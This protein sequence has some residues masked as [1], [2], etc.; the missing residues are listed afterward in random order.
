MTGSSGPDVYLSL[1]TLM[2][3][4]GQD[5]VSA[6]LRGSRLLLCWRVNFDAGSTFALGNYKLR[7]RF[8][9]SPNELRCVGEILVGKL[10]L[11]LCEGEGHALPTPLARSIKKRRSRQSSRWHLHLEA[12]RQYASR[13]RLRLLRLRRVRPLQV[14]WWS[15]FLQDRRPRSCQTIAGP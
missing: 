12:L 5:R 15:S 1:L 10:F 6:M 4:A 2:Q 14:G 8:C 3:Y 7:E 9:K 13:T 11:E